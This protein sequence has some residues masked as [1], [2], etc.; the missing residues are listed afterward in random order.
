M[1]QVDL[2]LGNEPV[3]DHRLTFDRNQF[4]G[5]TCEVMIVLEQMFHSEPFISSNSH[6]SAHQLFI[7]DGKYL[8]KRNQ[9]R[10][11]NG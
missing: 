5:W 3:N 7:A 8:M 11:T 2:R 9:L 4:C 6:I 10:L 1:R